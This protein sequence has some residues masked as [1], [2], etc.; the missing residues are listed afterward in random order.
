MS[1]LLDL[2][3]TLPLER[4]TLRLEWHTDERALGVF[5]PSGA[6]KTS[7]LEAIA[8]L[9]TEARGQVRVSGRTWLD[10]AAGVCLPPER[11]G[12]GYVPQDARLF[13]HLDVRGNL[14][15]G[16]RSASG[17]RAAG[18]DPDRVTEILELRGREGDPVSSLSGGER[19]RVALGR[20]LCRRPEILLLDEPLG[21]LDRPLR[22]RI[23]PYLLRVERE[24]GV[25][26]ILVSHDAAE[27]RLLCREAVVL[28]E[29]RT[30]AR[31][32]PDDV[33]TGHEML[34]RLGVPAHANIIRGFARSIAGAVATIGAGGHTLTAPA[35]SDVAAGAEVAL[36]VRAEEL[37]VATDAPQGL[38][39]Q[40]VLPAT[41]RSLGEETTTP[42]TYPDGTAVAV[43]ADV[44]GLVAPLVAAVTAPACRRLGLAPGSRIYLVWKT[45]ACRVVPAGPVHAKEVG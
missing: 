16:R 30:A 4:Y 43:T 25:P 33:F 40:N 1:D 14:L 26:S 6:G 41:I 31:G 20:A 11:R 9:R 12:V 17:D 38:S 3:L 28:I 18:L 7:L 2:D 19:Q 22:R 36:L 44:P 23:L 45:H 35:A 39:A 5:G 13:P 42:E 24:F 34:A 15:I 21:G 27:V 8:G 29:G 37:I 32:R 10:S